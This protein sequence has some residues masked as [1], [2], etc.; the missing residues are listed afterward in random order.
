M[1][2]TQRNL[3]CRDLAISV[4]IDLH[5]L[6]SLSKKSLLLLHSYWAGPHSDKAV[7]NIDVKNSVI[8]DP[9]N[10]SFSTPFCIIFHCRR[11]PAR[12]CDGQ[13]FPLKNF[14]TAKVVIIDLTVSAIVA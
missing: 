10:F 1:L 11:N 4:G 14:T 12:L 5:Y 7:A 8:F 3:K 13:V 2:T 9:S 6:S